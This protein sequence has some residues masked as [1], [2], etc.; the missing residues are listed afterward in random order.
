[1]RAQLPHMTRPGGAIVNVSSTCGIRGLQQV[2]AYCASKHG[3]IGITKA[4]AAEY[5]PKGIR[6]NAVCP[7]AL[8]TPIFRL[9]ESQGVVKASIFEEGTLLKRMGKPEEVAQVLAFLLSDKASY[10]TGC[11]PFCL[12][13]MTAAWTVDGGFTAT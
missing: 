10:V 12:K 6:I 11:I 5:G 4:A 2:S 13:L 1:M 3:V 7:G 9:A 8:D